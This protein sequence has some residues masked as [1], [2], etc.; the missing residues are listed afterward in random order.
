MTDALIKKA[1]K[2]FVKIKIKEN[3]SCPKKL[4]K[5]LKNLG[6]PTKVNEAFS[7]IGLKNEDDD[8]CFDSDFVANKFNRYFCNIAEKLVDKL[9]L[10][11]YR[12]DRVQDYYKEMGIERNSFKFNVVEQLEV[13]N[14]LRYLDIS[15]SAGEDKISGKFLRDAA[16]VISSPLTYIMNLS[17]K[18]ATVPDDFKLARVLPYIKK[19]TEIMKETIDRC[20]SYRLHQKSLKKLYTIRCTNI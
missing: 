7:N 6:I 13:E 2:D 5:T 16:E 10:R 4:W 15:K 8:V 19:E 9:P 3:K 18:S 17:L 1:K 20:Q 14:M 11:T 12:E